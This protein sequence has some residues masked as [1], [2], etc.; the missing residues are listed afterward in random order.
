MSHYVYLHASNVSE[1]RTKLPQPFH[2]GDY[3]VGLTEIALANKWQQ[4]NSGV[5]VLDVRGVVMAFPLRRAKYGRAE[6]LNEINR[7]VNDKADP[8]NS[9]TILRDLLSN[10]ESFKLFMERVQDRIKIIQRGSHEFTAND[11]KFYVNEAQQAVIQRNPDVIRGVWLSDDLCPMLGFRRNQNIDGLEAKTAGSATTDQID[12]IIV[13]ADIIK[14]STV[15]EKQLQIIDRIVLSPL[16]KKSTFLKRSYP[17][18]AYTQLQASF[19]ETVKIRLEDSNGRPVNAE[20]IW[21]KLHF[22]SRWAR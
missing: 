11:I 9:L 14:A 5:V 1:F 19:I 17:N 12:A 13:H 15:N 2:S 8:E 21:L 20:N 6:L 4:L 7:L 18:P 3:S 22:R 16:E 10:N